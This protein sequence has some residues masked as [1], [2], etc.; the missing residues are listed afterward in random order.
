MEAK[1]K[2]R[3]FQFSLW[4][5]MIVVTLLAVPLGYVGWQAKIVRERNTLAESLTTLGRTQTKNGNIPWLR[6]ML[7]DSVYDHITLC[8]SASDELMAEYM[9]TFPEAVIERGQYDL[10]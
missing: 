8:R 5:L 9:A 3:W 1:P 10:R 7:G 6:R 2:R 4:T